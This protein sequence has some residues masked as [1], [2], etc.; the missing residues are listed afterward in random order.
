MTTPSRSRTALIRVALSAGVMIATATIATPQSQAESCDSHELGERRDA[1]TEL[2]EQ[3]LLDPS[4][5]SEEELAE[6]EHDY[7]ECERT[8]GELVSATIAPH[9]P[10]GPVAGAAPLRHNQG[11]K[12]D[13]DDDGDDDDDDDGNN[14][15]GK[16]DICH[17]RG[18]GSF[19]LI[20]ISV[21]AEPAH[22]AHGD[23]V[24]GETVPGQAGLVFSPG[25]EFVG[26]DIEKATEGEDADAGP[27]ITE[28]QSVVWSYVVANLGAVP[29][30]D[31]QVDDDQGVSVSC[32]LST[33]TVG[34]S[35]SCTALGTTTA[36]Q[37]RNVGTVTGTGAE[38]VVSDSDASHYFGEEE[39]PGLDVEKAV[40]GLDADEEPGLLIVQGE[41]VN[42]LYVVTNTGDVDLLNVAVVD[43]QGVAVTCPQSSLTPGELITCTGSD[44]AVA[45][46]YRNIGTASGFSPLSKL[47]SDS[48]P[49][50]YFG[51]ERNP[52]LADPQTVTTD[53]G[54]PIV[55]TLTGSDPEEGDLTFSI[56][57]QPTAG[58][59]SSPVHIVPDTESV[60]DRDGLPT[61]DVFQPP[62]TSATV[63]YTPASDANV[64]DGFIFA[65][66][67]PTGAT[68]TAVVLINPADETD[69]PPPPV[70]DVDAKDV[71]AE[72]SVGTP[73]TVILEAEA[74]PEA[75]LTFTILSL[76]ATGAL[77]ETSGAAIE[78]VP[79][80]LSSSQVV[81]TPA[82]GF[83]GTE[84][85]SYEASATAGVDSATATVDVAAPA[86]LTPDQVVGTPANTPL[87]ITLPANRGGS[88]STPNGASAF[89]GQQ[90][91]AGQGRDASARHRRWQRRGYDG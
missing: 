76:P 73:V 20:R 8:L 38:T 59:L 10:L 86:E 63:T 39:R 1:L 18:K 48:D 61:G 7:T 21:N 23:A 12:D 9:L 70:D 81:Y 90:W 25:C 14:G 69:D 72:T 67:D 15:S 45:G 82:A 89:A 19:R 26:I 28:G 29:L 50:H 74:P 78:T 5:V 79:F 71:F 11:S 35:M 57:I 34:A 58:T 44:T 65:V 31:V 6:A 46:R 2:R 88:G 32:P 84:T 3:R 80:A 4:G 42:F 85:F 83:T 36:G 30:S 60:I 24:P 41:P 43:D 68:G 52:P 16:V 77:S 22:R 17:L 47:V 91:R 75:S 66:T 33:L 53:G 55:I 87:E 62:V 37:Y 13:D 56:E 54:D 27:T 64:E 51:E 40:N 49:S